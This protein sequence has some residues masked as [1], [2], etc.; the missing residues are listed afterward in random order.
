[1]NY[2]Y[3][4]ATSET[5]NILLHKNSFVWHEVAS[6]C[7][8]VLL[9][10]KSGA[11]FFGKLALPYVDVE[12]S[13]GK[14]RHYLERSNCGE[15][16]LNITDLARTL[17]TGDKVCLSGKRLRWGKEAELLFFR[18]DVDCATRV[19]VI[20]PHP[21]DAELS[22]FGFYS[23]YNSTVVT[24]T[25]GESGK[26]FYQKFYAKDAKKQSLIKA[27]LRVFDSITTPLLGYVN[28]NDIIN[29]GYFDDRLQDMK[30]KPEKVF[31]S[32]INDVDDVNFYR[33]FNVSNLV[34][35]S[36]G[37][38]TWNNLLQDLVEVIARVK[39]NII[40]TPHPVLD[41]HPDHKMSSLAVFEALKKLNFNDGRFF[42]Y[43][44]HANFSARYPYGKK[45][46]PI[47]VPP[48]FVDLGIEHGV[49]SHPLNMGMQVEKTFALDTMH[50]LRS[51]P[52]HCAGSCCWLKRKLFSK[53]RHINAWRD[54]YRK[55]VR[56]NELFFVMPFASA[57]DEYI[58]IA[59]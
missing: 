51:V 20:A 53:Y 40:V 12:Y 46:T 35:K 17:K 49:Y 23:Q 58:S 32:K 55:S 37:N 9:K 50:E 45:H 41:K 39:P 1:L 6:G 47:T 27:R 21:D 44:N 24:I 26:N 31:Y 59:S 57:I 3:S 38:A 36:D 34:P 15:R 42:F 52:D 28:S 56:A 14:I 22:A 16:Y 8:T 13:G 30:R 10:L 48:N 25:C 43:V 4:F 19:L 7:D 18:N 29:L 54:Y 2:N 33:I 5:R 11:K